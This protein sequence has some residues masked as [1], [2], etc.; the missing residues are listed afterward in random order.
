M[1][2][3]GFLG[4]RPTRSAALGHLL[5]RQDGHLRP[6]LE[7]IRPTGHHL[8]IDQHFSSLQGIPCPRPRGVSHMGHECF[9]QLNRMGGLEFLH[10]AK[11]RVRLGLAASPSK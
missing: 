9:D 8:T 5:F 6:W 7:D 4:L 1:R 3:L 11:V 10:G 2:W